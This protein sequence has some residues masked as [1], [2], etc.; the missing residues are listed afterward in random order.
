MSITDIRAGL[1]ANLE[2]VS[3][4]RAYSEI[5]DNPQV[6]C[7]VVQLQTIEYDQS[8][9]KGLAFYNFEIT[10][11]VGRFSVQQAQEHLNDYADN[12]GAKSI[13]SAI[14]SDKTLGGSAFDAHLTTMTGISALDLN[15]G[16]NYLGMTFSVTVYAD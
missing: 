8:F 9:Q 11:I 5:P 13:K 4:L 14:E 3:G 1:E 7:A 6:P 2:T 12:S 16:N 15:D 10:V